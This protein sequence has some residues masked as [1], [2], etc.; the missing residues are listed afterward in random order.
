MRM[1]SNH[2]HILG[3]PDASSGTS[4]T[5]CFRFLVTWTSHEDYKEVMSNAW[6]SP[7]ED[8]QD[9]LAMVKTNSIHFNKITFG[10]ISKER[11]EESR[12]EFEG[13][14]I[15]ARLSCYF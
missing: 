12:E 15:R 3:R 9:K 14:A 7:R 6:R 4:G 5:R 1:Y 8:I 10:N 11:G 2:N 13:C